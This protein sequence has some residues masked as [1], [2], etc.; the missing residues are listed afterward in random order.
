MVDF[1]TQVVLLGRYTKNSVS[2]HEGDIERHED[3]ITDLRTRVE[4]LETKD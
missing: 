2:R 1:G 3:E 4:K